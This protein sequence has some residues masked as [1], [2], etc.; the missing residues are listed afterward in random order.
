M[1]ATSEKPVMS[2]CTVR[3]QKEV[4]LTIAASPCGS[5]CFTP[6]IAHTCRTAAAVADNSM[7]LKL[8]CK[9][10][11]QPSKLQAVRY[12]QVPITDN[13]GSQQ[14]V[15]SSSDDGLNSKEC[16]FNWLHTS[17]LRLNILQQAAYIEK[18]S[19]CTE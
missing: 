9:L 15:S 10:A 18:H 11:W 3:R 16:P 7:C 19:S 4:L 2:D 8:V 6:W 14:G 13:F 1:A 17:M 12:T 5:L